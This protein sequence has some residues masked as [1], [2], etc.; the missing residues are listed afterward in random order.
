MD[1]LFVILG[2]PGAGRR[3]IVTQLLDGLHGETRVYIAR[4][5]KRDED[6]DSLA[7]LEGVE[8]VEWFTD[9]EQLEIPDA[10]DCPSRIVFITEGLR[11]PVDQLEIIAALGPRIGWAVT[12]VITV[13]D[14]ALTTRIPALADWY[15]VCIHFSDVVILNRREG[16]APSF[17]RDFMAP[18]EKNCTPALFERTRKGRLANPDLILSDESRRL[19]QVFD[20]DRDAIYDMKFDEDELPEEPFDLAHKT[21]PYFERDNS[22]ARVI[23]IPVIADLLK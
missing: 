22:G 8:I 11:N 9:G 1:E 19:T 21:D 15:K 7:K 2:T 18:Y 17:D 3:A 10:D 13:V 4:G 5:E 23:R 16:V 12:R 20:T 6:E 14:C